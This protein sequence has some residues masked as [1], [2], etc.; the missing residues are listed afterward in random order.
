VSSLQD[1]QQ[2]QLQ[3]LRYCILKS[4]P[5]PS[6]AVRGLRPVFVLRLERIVPGLPAIDVRVGGGVASEREVNVVC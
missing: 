5:T 3:Q 6:C 2:L 4:L 1:R